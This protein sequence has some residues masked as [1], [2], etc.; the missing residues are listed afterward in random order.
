MELASLEA[1]YCRRIGWDPVII[2]WYHGL[3]YFETWRFV[4]A[5][6]RPFVQHTEESLQ[7]DLERWL[8]EAGG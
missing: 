2:Q 8:V 7:R 6:G 5:S 1:R 3:E 4:S